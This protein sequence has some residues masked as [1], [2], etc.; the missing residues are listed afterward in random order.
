MLGMGPQFT[1]EEVGKHDLK[2][3]IWVVIDNNVY[4]LTKFKNKKLEGI[5]AIMHRAGKEAT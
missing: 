5:D 4:D 1:W 2:D 3:D